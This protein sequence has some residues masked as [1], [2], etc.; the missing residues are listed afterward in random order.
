MPYVIE[1]S[2][3]REIWDVIKTFSPIIGTLIGVVVGFLLST[4][5]RQY[6]ENRYAKNRIAYL[7]SEFVNVKFFTEWKPIMSELRETIL[8]NDKLR[9]RNVGFYEKWLANSDCFPESD[10]AGLFLDE[11]TKIK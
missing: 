5:Y 6:T 1:V 4:I 2:I 8:T 10:N 11:L 7:R 3:K 9:K